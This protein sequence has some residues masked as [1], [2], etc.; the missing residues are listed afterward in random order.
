MN[1]T[2]GVGLTSREYWTLSA[3]SVACVMLVI[4]NISLA[5]GNREMRSQVTKRQVFITQSVQLDKV[6]KKLINAVAQL[7]VRD[8]DSALERVLTDQGIQIR[9]NDAPAA[10]DPAQ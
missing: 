5:Q 10:S 6:N 1:D 9:R 8:N 7:S 2:T 4:I 3:V